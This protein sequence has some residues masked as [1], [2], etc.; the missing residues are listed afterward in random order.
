[1][2]GAGFEGEGDLKVC[3]GFGVGLGV[4]LVVADDLLRYHGGKTWKELEAEGK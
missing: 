3:W 2:V 4:L 1:V